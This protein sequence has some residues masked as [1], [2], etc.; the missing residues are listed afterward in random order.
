MTFIYNCGDESVKTVNNS[1]H[2]PFLSSRSLHEGLPEFPRYSQYAICSVH[3]FV[4]PF[5]KIRQ[6]NT[7]LDLN[8]RRKCC[9]REKVLC[10]VV[11]FSLR[12]RNTRT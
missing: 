11:I 4:D 5:I 7:L 2:I 12:T 3:L 9:S 10:S 8:S 6:I 1:I